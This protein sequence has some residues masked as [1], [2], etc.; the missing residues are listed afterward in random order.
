MTEAFIVRRGSGAG[1]NFKVVGGTTQPANTIQNTIWVNTDTEI[2]SYT[3]SGDAPNSNS[4]TKNLILYPYVTS[5]TTI[6][7]VTITDNGDGTLTANGTT[8]GSTYYVLSS[9]GNKEITLEPGTYTLS[10]GASNERYYRLHLY[11]SSDNWTTEQEVTCYGTPVTFTITETCVARVLINI[12]S[13]NVAMSNVIFKPQLELGD[14]ATSFIKGVAAEEGMVWFRT[15]STSIGAF[16]ALKKS[17]LMVYIVAVSQYVGGVWESKVAKIWQSGGWVSF[18]NYVFKNGNIGLGGG[19]VINSGSESDLSISDVITL[20]CPQYSDRSWRSKEPIDVTAFKTMRISG[21][22]P[23]A[24]TSGNVYTTIGLATESQ[25]STAN[26]YTAFTGVPY[27]QDTPSEVSIDV[28][29]LE[30]QYYVVFWWHSGTGTGE[31]HLKTY[32][33]EFDV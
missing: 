3:F 9:K 7:G 20:T 33:V 28:S 32:Y 6:N 29:A 14:T 1:L 19:I 5:T 13:A 8:T 18:I 22:T 27:S 16:N 15:G 25:L 31:Q 11:Y 2:P 4:Q 30:G 21:Y 24:G 26:S 17:T 10:L 23:W 12:S